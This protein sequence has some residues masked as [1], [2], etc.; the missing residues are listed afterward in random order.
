MSKCPICC[1]AHAIGNQATCD[2]KHGMPISAANGEWLDCRDFEAVE[3]VAPVRIAK[4]ECVEPVPPAVVEAERG[5]TLESLFL[6]CGTFD[7]VSQ[8]EEEEDW[9]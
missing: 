7:A 2:L 1:F 9:L 8:V 5:D 3:K 4:R 6:K